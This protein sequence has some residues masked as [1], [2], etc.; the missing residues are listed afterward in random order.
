MQSRA[1]RRKALIDS[2]LFVGEHEGTLDWGGLA[3]SIDVDD[4]Q[5]QDPLDKPNQD[6][7]VSVRSFISWGNVR[8][9]RRRIPCSGLIDA[10]LDSAVGRWNWSLQGV[11]VVLNTTQGKSR[12]PHL[13]VVGLP[14]DFRLRSGVRPLAP[15]RSTPYRLLRPCSSQARL[16]MVGWLLASYV[17]M[18]WLYLGL[19]HYLP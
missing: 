16:A 13:W 15:L 18:R 8:P 4:S 12:L 2:F 19:R 7:I 11:V 1:C 9:R 17:Y 3:S 14:I 6:L 5:S 10:F